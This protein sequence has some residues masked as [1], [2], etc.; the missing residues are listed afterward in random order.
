[1][2][3][4]LLYFLLH[5]TQLPKDSTTYSSIALSHMCMSLLF[6][7]LLDGNSW[8]VVL[9]KQT[10]NE[11]HHEIEFVTWTFQDEDFIR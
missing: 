1:M 11:H 10:W 6:D 4:I 9:S 8:D 2:D 5:S 3:F 7:Y